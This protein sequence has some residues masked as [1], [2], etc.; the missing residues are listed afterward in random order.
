[1][2]C[3]SDPF[4]AG[5]GASVMRVRGESMRPGTNELPSGRIAAVLPV[6]RIIRPTEAA[7]VPKRLERHAPLLAGTGKEFG[8]P[9]QVRQAQNREVFRHVNERIADLADWVTVDGQPLALICECATTGCTTT[10]EVPYE[11]YGR[12]RQADATYLVATGHEDPE[13]EEVVERHSDFPIIRTREA[14]R[15][16][17]EPTE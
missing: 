14:R 10:L 6:S 8:V 11:V 4:A 9:R 12:V 15:A 1:M 2:R 5:C 17:A 7:P 16:A 13:H 3:Q